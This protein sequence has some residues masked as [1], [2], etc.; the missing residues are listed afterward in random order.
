MKT[1]VISILACC[2]TLAVQGQNPLNGSN[3]GLQQ[4]PTQQSL[5]GSNPGLQQVPT[6]QALNGSN[7]GLQQVPQARSFN[8]GIGVQPYMPPSNPI[9]QG[10]YPSAYSYVV[11]PVDFQRLLSAV[12]AQT[13]ASNQLPMIQAAGLCGWFTTSQCAQLMQL[14]DFDDNRLQVLRYLAPH[15]VDPYYYNPVLNALNF[16]SSQQTARDILRSMSR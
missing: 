4:L 11:S 2:A 5:N 8:N 16:M 13:F 1:F 14:F 10:P 7:P 15:I 12:N 6:Q 9:Y 3:P